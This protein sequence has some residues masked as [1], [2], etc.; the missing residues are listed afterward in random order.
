MRSAEREARSGREPL[1]PS[2]A[3]LRTDPY[4]S[5]RRHALSAW[6]AAALRADGAARVLL[7][8]PD[9]GPGAA[10]LAGAGLRVVSAVA[11]AER[12]DALSRTWSGVDFR[13]APIPRTFEPESAYDA[14]VCCSLIERLG[15]PRELLVEAQR[16]LREGGRFVVVTPNRLR[17]SPRRTRPLRGEHAWEYTASELHNLIRWRFARPQIFGLHHGRALHALE[18]VLGEPLTVALHRLSP[19]DRT[20]W[21]RGT[22]RTIGPRSFTV[23]DG[24]LRD[25]VDLIGTG[26]A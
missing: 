12:A 15:D 22:L 14:V 13:A 26:T 24:Q 20:A 16:V 25:A 5:A 10:I 4:D 9:E 23:S 6:L 7:V 3:V 1:R 2:S 18:R 19:A 11:D 17:W 21:L 8:G